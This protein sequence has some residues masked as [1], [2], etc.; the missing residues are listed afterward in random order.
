MFSQTLTQMLDIKLNQQDIILPQGFE[1]VMRSRIISLGE[2]AFS[3]FAVLHW[4]TAFSTSS[5]SQSFP[6][7]SP[8]GNSSYGMISNPRDH[9]H[10]NSSSGSRSTVA[11]S[12]AYSADVQATPSRRSSMLPPFTNM[13]QMPQ[14]NY[15]TNAMNFGAPSP[16]TGYTA[17]FANNTF[18]SNDMAAPSRSWYDNEFDNPQTR[19]HAGVPPVDINSVDFAGLSA[20]VMSTPMTEGPDSEGRNL[21]GLPDWQQLTPPASSG[22]MRFDGRTQR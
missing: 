13:Q 1:E 7:S 21:A 4:P 22:Q 11:H 18:R 3:V 8:F 16:V 10:R 14:P 20:D 19:F 2:R 12:R 15:G 17:P 6:Q 9:F 5:S